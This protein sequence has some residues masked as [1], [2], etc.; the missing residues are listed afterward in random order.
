MWGV[1]HHWNQLTY[2]QVKY[3]NPVLKTMEQGGM[4]GCIKGERLL[5]NSKCSCFTRVRADVVVKREISYLGGV[6]FGIL[7]LERNKYI[8]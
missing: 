1:K 8:Q 6:E 2:G 4:R 3:I 5:K 7:R